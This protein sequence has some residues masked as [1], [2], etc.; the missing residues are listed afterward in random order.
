MKEI[1]K[2]VGKE[3]RGGCILPLYMELEGEHCQNVWQEGFTVF[4]LLEIQFTA[5]FYQ[6]HVRL[7][8]NL[9]LASSSV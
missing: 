4:T 6:F 7:V 8:L 3:G 2:G 5:H 9:D 1:G